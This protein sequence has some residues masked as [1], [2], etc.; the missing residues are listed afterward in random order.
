LIQG[1]AKATTR[2]NVD[3]GVGLLLDL[4]QESFEQSRVLTRHTCL[5][6][7]RMQMHHG[8]ARCGDRLSP[9]CIGAI[10]PGY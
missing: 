10:D 7:P 4:R 3:N 8:G 5:G 6:D 9:I 2:R 1:H